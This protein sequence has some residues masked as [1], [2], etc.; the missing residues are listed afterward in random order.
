M[1]EP[2]SAQTALA[3]RIA[4]K[5]CLAQ[6]Y[7]E[8]VV[9]G[10]KGVPF[11]HDSCVWSC[12]MKDK[13]HGAADGLLLWIKKGVCVYGSLSHIG[14]EMTAEGLKL[15]F[16]FMY[17][18]NA[19]IGDS[20]NIFSDE[21]RCYCSA[22]FERPLFSDSILCIPKVHSQRES[23]FWKTHQEFLLSRNRLLSIFDILTISF[24]C[25]AIAAS[26]SRLYRTG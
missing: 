22:V 9:Q 18:G 23:Q 14:L 7:K 24:C 11:C 16:Q 17:Q 6:L 10:G 19:I 20:T 1:E 5:D 26:V 8:E 2:A 15:L 12:N 4:A 3:R 25:V 21:K 13:T